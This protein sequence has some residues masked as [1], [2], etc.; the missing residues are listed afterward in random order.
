MSDVHLTTVVRENFGFMVVSLFEEQQSVDERNTSPG[1][2]R[3]VASTISSITGL[4]KPTGS[5]QSQHRF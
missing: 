2:T 5:F 1:K 4:A 3:I